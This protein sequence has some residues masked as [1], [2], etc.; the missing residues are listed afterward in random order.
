MIVANKFQTGF[1]EPKLCAMYVDKKL[2]G[3]DCVQTLSRLN[4]VFPGKRTFILDFVNDPE[5]VL[6]AFRP[7]YNKAELQ[8]VSDPNVVYDLQQKLDA[9]GIYQWDEVEAFARAFFDPKGKQ[10]QLK[11]AVAPAQD[12]FRQRYADAEE[13]IRHWRVARREAE[14][15]GDD[16]GRQRADHELE[17]AGAERDKLEVFRKDLGSFVRTY[18][19]LSQIVDYDDTD[20]EK[21]CVFAK[22]LSGL[23]TG[24]SLASEEIDLSEVELTHYRLTKQKEHQLN[25]RET[26]GEYQIRPVNEVGSGEPRDPEHK[27]LSEIIERLNELF[28][29][30]VSDAHKLN[31]A[32]GVADQLERDDTAMAEMCQNSREQLRHGRFPERVRD[33]VMDR[34]NEEQEMSLPILD[35]DDQ[36]RAFTE[37]I[38][39]MLLSRQGEERPSSPNG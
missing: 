24:P 8:D 36:A 32:T 39:D 29:A 3:V 21:L 4:R 30:N 27:R 22:N 28:G 16:S 1:D 18:E 15:R 6:A 35:S 38:V 2:Q 33:I 14:Q 7:Y 26:E 37:L 11:N 20:L 17:A 23:L 9:T 5:D 31:F 12:R 19:F 34:M 25:L 13:R 10:A